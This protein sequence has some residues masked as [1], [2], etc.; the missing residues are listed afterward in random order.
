MNT[1]LPATLGPPCAPPDLP[2]DHDVKELRLALVCY[3]GVSLAIYMHGI[4]KELEKLVRAS[5]RALTVSENP[6]S[7]G[8]TEY[9]YFNALK[10]KAE[11]DGFRTSVVVDIIS[12]TSAGGSTASVWRRRSPRTRRKT[13][14]ATSG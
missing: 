2:D 10:R 1:P 9:A 5:K 14:Y 6:F 13:V 7:P 8:E 4:T 12:G 11:G 3:G